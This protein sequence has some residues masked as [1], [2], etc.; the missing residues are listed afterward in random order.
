MSSRIVSVWLTGLVLACAPASTADRVGQMESRIVDLEAQLA[1][2]ERSNNT[3][4]TRITQLEN[5]VAAAASSLS[6]RE[7][8]ATVASVE[9]KLSDLTTGLE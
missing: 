4:E 6:V 7:V 9:A 5:R 8:A 3:L 1:R 2:A